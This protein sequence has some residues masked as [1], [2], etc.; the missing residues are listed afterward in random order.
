MKTETGNKLAVSLTGLHDA[1]LLAAVFYAPIIWGQVQIPETHTSVQWSASTGQA[2]EAGLLGL[3]LLAALLARWAQGKPP[4]RIP[5][6]IHLPALLLLFM[7]AIATIFSINHHVSKLELYR[8]GMGVVLFYLVANRALLPA[9]KPSLVAAAFACSAIIIALGPIEGETAKAL[10]IFSVIA[11]GITIAVMVTPRED[12][13]P[14]KWWRYA[15]IISAA[16]VVSMLG[17]REKFIVAR[18]LEN[19]SW[20][21]FS[22]FFNPNPL[23]GFLAMICP[24][25]LAAAIAT[26][27]LT[28]RLLWGFCA[29]ALAATIIPT[30]SKGAL[31]ALA[32]ALVAFALMLSLQARRLR[33]LTL[34]V[35]LIIGLTFLIGGLGAWFSPLLRARVVSALD[36]HSASNMFRILT[37]KGTV[38]LFTAHPWTGVGPA[39]FKYVY[40]NYAIAGYVEAAHQNYLQMFAELGVFGGAIFLWLLGAI[41][42]TGRRAIALSDDLS[43]RVLA[44]GG[45]SGIIVLLVHSFLDYDWYIGAINLSFWLIAGMLAYQANGLT[46]ETAPIDV[47]Q[48]RGKK[49]RQN[50]TPAVSAPKPIGRNF[51]WPG[52]PR[53]STRT[54]CWLLSLVILATLWIGAI[55][56]PAR[57]ALAQLALDTGDAYAVSGRP[58]AGLTSLSKYE[59]ATK[60]DPGWSEAWERYGLILGLRDL[61][62]GIESLARAQQLSPTSFR[63][64]ISLGQLYE[65]HNRYADAIKTYE[66][67]LTL[68][69]NHTRTMKRI[70]DAYQRLG[71]YD[72][73]LRMWEKLVAGE[74][75][76][77]NKYRALSEV[78]VDTNF[79]FAH[80]ELGLAAE[81]THYMEK[82][83]SLGVALKEYFAALK[84][85]DE[86]FAKAKQM[87]DM[88]LMLGRPR[89]YRA[90]D[91]RLLQAMIRW[92]IGEVYAR[93]GDA[94]QA[95]EN[96]QLALSLYPDLLSKINAIQPETPR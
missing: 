40:P 89:E 41:L 9:A 79:A 76:P 85:I 3:A 18:E 30:H 15:L 39:A 52:N 45:L 66:K 63:P 94:K 95:E 33:P 78:D 19:K 69:P 64:Y 72:D 43:G 51:P 80:Y 74:N 35:L 92:R 26:R 17:W 68:F 14:I 36:L 12:P 11:L 29:I 59:Q 77:Y 58:N 87:D 48:P 93:V 60:D 90:E 8:L 50:T 54:V 56:T 1:A 20:S 4:A 23:G 5:N 38:H 31:L 61:D 96:H 65:Q 24:L 10:S 37:W 70:A 91:M 28:R 88:F 84:I 34:V 25:A 57:N 21:I 82:K 53:K 7:A 67:A 42:F 2:V 81:R 71:Q 46:L 32:V 83:D 55:V 13:D 6:A 22:T 27:D 73:S 47:E 44:I 16:L 62:K 75:A 86:Y 49:R